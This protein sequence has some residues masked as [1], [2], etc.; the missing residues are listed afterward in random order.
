MNYV[1]ST[2]SRLGISTAALAACLGIHKTTLV[3]AEHGKG[4]LKREALLKLH[5]YS[6]MIASE[7]DAGEANMSHA[8]IPGNQE[9]QQLSLSDLYKLV[10]LQRKLDKMKALFTRYK[11][12]QLI[13]SALETND[14][15]RVHW[16][17][18]EQK[19]I[20][21]RLGTCNETVQAELVKKLQQLVA[22]TG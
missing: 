4:S 18:L 5:Q 3:R 2:R 14:P 7:T 9:G 1:K 12:Y 10:Y 21:A 20:T 19:K 11:N 15:A 16:V 17:S 8:V 6:I 13:L 22:T